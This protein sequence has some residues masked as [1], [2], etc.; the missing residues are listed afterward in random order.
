LI[1]PLEN[2]RSDFD[3]RVHILLSSIC[4]LGS[5]GSLSSVGCVG[6]TGSFGI[7]GYVGSIWNLG[8]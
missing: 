7:V 2:I 5:T 4:C 1:Y 8:S 6:S 3:L